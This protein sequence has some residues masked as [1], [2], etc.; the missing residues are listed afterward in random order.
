MPRKKV[1]KSLAIV[2][3]EWDAEVDAAYLEALA[4]LTQ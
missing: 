4:Q 2:P 1:V 3:D